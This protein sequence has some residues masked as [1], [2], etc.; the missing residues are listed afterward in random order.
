MRPACISAAIERASARRLV[1]RKSQAARHRLVDMKMRL[2]SARLLLYRACWEIDQGSRAT[3]E[4]ALAKLAVSESMVRT[5]MDAFE[6]L[7]AEACLVSNGFERALR[8]SLAGTIFSGTS[9][10]HR[11]L[12]AREM[13]L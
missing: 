4:V 3:Q 9:E 6:L 13:G 8:D 5:S 1:G 2:E 11:E 7:G 12:I 10:I